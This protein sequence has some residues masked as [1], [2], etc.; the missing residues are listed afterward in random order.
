MTT[1]TETGKAQLKIHQLTKEQYDNLSVVSPTEL[2]VVDMGL[3]GGKVLVSTPDGDIV[4]GPFVYNVTDGDS[5]VLQANSIYNAG[6]ITTLS[7][8]L[9]TNGDMSF[10]AQLSFTNNSTSSATIT[11]S[12]TMKW[13]GDDCIENVFTPQTNYRYTIM[14]TYDGQNWVGYARGVK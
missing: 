7:L 13:I 14:I 4:E 12:T 2:Y 9:P 11:P 10:I 5:V 8:T 1:T 6:T 3:T